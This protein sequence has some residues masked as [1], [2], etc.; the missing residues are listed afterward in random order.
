MQ[1]PGDS[2][3][4]PEKVL[5]SWGG[6]A[7]PPQ[8]SRSCPPPSLWTQHSLSPVDHCLRQNLLMF[9]SGPWLTHVGSTWGDELP[10]QPEEKQTGP[11]IN[12]VVQGKTWEAQS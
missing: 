1:E 3:A 8:P 11:V 5:H 2:P 9:P 4:H 7:F 6:W 10:S 12:T